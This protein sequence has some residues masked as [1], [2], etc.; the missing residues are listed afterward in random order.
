MF[1]KVI[2]PCLFINYAYILLWVRRHL[3]ETVLWGNITWTE[4]GKQNI[5]SLCSD[6]PPPSEK[7]QENRRLWIAV[8]N[9]VPAVSPECWGKPLIGC[10]V[11]TINDGD[12]QTSVL[13]ILFWGRG[14]VCTQAKH[15][16]QK[17]LFASSQ[18]VQGYVNTIL[19]RFCASTIIWYRCSYYAG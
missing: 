19:V 13:P 8:V 4:T 5:H 17:C 6:V 11:N 3:K 14:D 7:N 15:T 9:R 12:S 1:S 18:G 10:N 2:Y 16:S